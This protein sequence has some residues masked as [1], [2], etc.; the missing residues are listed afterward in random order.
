[1]LEDIIQNN[2]PEC[3]DRAGVVM[4]SLFPNNPQP[5]CGHY[6]IYCPYQ[7]ENKRYIEC[8]YMKWMSLFNYLREQNGKV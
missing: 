6:E 1:M 5:M 8:D 7:R 4:I 2:P 3:V